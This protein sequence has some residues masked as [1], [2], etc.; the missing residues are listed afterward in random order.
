[1]NHNGQSV[2]R[3]GTDRGL[4]H[5]P[6]KLRRRRFEAGLSIT[7]AALAAGYSKAHLSMLES[8]EDHSASPECL[9]ELAR[10]YECKI[11]DL[12]PDEPGNGG[13]AA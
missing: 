11:A 10:V 4:A 12:L 1:M 3:S 7:K 6:R 2:K 5:D 13:R 8:G 9:R